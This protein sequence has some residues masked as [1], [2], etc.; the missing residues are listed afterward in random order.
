[1]VWKNRKVIDVLALVAASLVATSAFA[2][3]KELLEHCRIAQQ[4]I[5]TG[6]D[7]GGNLLA[8]RCI[9]YAEGSAQ[10]LNI[11]SDHVASPA[12]VCLPK[13]LSRGQMVSVL[14]DYLEAHPHQLGYPE[15]VLAITAYREAFPCPAK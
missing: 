1:M 5:K 9:G 15:P 6:Q 10:V 3:G 2:D 14:F 13:M 8:G 7:Q 12:R 4:Y 11:V